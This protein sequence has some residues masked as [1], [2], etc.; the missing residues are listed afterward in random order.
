MTIRRGG[1]G[2]TTV[3]CVTGASGYVAS[4]LVKLLLLR[5]FTVRASVRDPSDLNKTKHL[6]ALD[7][8]KERLHLFKADILEEGSFDTEIDGCEGVFHTASPCNLYVTEENARAELI[9]PAI[10]GTINVLASCARVTS[11]RRVVLTSSSSAVIYNGW[12]RTPDV[13]VDETWYSTPD[14]CEKLKVWYPLAKTLAEDAA[15][16][17]AKEKGIDMVVMNPAVCIGP[18]LRPALNVGATEIMKLINGESFRN[19]SFGWVNIKDAV[20][21]HI[22]AFEIP[23]AS[24]RYFLTER[25]AHLSE[26]VDIM[27]KLFPDFRLPEK[28]I[29]Q[30]VHNLLILRSIN[31]ELY[32]E[33][34]R[35]PVGLDHTQSSESGHKCEDDKPFMPIYL[36]SKEKAKSIG[37]DFMPLEQGIKE[38]IESLK[39]KGLLDC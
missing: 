2:R 38:T 21:A 37:I 35:R 10:K 33:V 17:F 13:V 12:P 11:V 30:T 31:T 4:W 26:I 18:L 1:G 28:F 36:A 15:W 6:L 20:N 27:R 25:V 34:Y 23:S 8:A 22:Q 16:K 7:G 3:V 5:G 32:K 39:D 24:G 9:D 29:S 14:V 19:F